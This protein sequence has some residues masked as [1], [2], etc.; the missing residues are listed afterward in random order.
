MHFH[1]PKPLHGWRAFTGEVGIIVVGVL[2]ALGFEQVV[3]AAHD[4]ATAAEA[5]VNIRA[6]LRGNLQ[7]IM[8]RQQSEA[9]EQK[10]LREIDSYLAAVSSGAKPRPLQWVGAPYAPLLY[11]A[12]FQSAQSAGKFFLLPEA[13]QKQLA[14]FYIGFDDF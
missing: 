8:L 11:H 2:I 1:L 12:N 13:E 7:T 3:S 6:E 10:R 5:R 14:A 9:C 4:R